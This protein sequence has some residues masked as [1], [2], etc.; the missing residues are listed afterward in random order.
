MTELKKY[1]QIQ[2]NEDETECKLCLD[3]ADT[4]DFYILEDIIDFLKESGIVYGINEN[5]ISKMI[6]EK[7]YERFVVVAN[8]KK[9]VDGKNGYYM[10]TF[11][12]SPNKKPKLRE[13]G[14]V[15]YLNLNLF[16]SVSEGELLARYISKVDGSDGCTVKGK[17]LKAAVAKNLPPLRGK[18]FTISEDCMEYYAAYDGK[19]DA[20]N[21]IINVTKVSTIPGN[22]DLNTGNLDVRGDLEIMGNVI[23]GMSIK[24]TGNITINGVVEASYITAGKNILIKRGILGGGRAKIEAG[25]NIFAQFIENSSIYSGDCVQANSVVNSIVTAY[26]DINIY[27]KTSSIVGGSLKANRMV[28]TKCIGSVGQVLTRIS[29]G[30]ENSIE[31]TLKLKE[32]KLQEEIE[33]LQKIEKAMKLLNAN[34]Q[35][36]DKEMLLLLTRSKIE[37]N[38]SIAELKRDIE[39]IR[40]RI[41]LAKSAEVVAEEMAYQGTIISIDGVILKLHNDYEKIVFIRRKDKILTKMYQEEDYASISA[42][43]DRLE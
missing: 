10:Y 7:I 42:A 5:I 25:G 14:S 40:M 38:A 39:N 12:T 20:S 15:D 18:G 30:V 1:I 24:A 16:Q 19:V 9:M 34:K 32:T 8:G 23:A 26:N 35:Q 33:E 6:G 37:K 28:R 11:N 21:G 29:V 36:A 17:V 41:E 3:M 31:A 13:D 2:I 27:G 4:P 22:V 43:P